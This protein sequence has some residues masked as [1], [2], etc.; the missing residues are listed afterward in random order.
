MDEQVLAVRDRPLDALERADGRDHTLQDAFQF[1]R[2]IALHL[3]K[4]G[5]GRK[6]RTHEKSLILIVSYEKIPGPTIVF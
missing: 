4:R 1:A 5:E 3:S 6:A 2:R